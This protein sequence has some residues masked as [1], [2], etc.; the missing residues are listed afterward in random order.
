MSSD[1][2]VTHSYNALDGYAAHM[3]DA[4]AAELAS[5]PDVAMV[6]PDG[7]CQGGSTQADAPWGIS[8]ISRKDKLPKGSS[9]SS[10]D[11]I[12][13]YRP[14]CSSI[15]VYLLSTGINSRHVDFGSRARQ[16]AIFGKYHAE[17]VN[18][19]GT[20]VAGIIGGKR[21]GIAKTASIISVK[22]IG[23]NGR[24]FVS[25]MIAGVNWAVN[26]AATTHQQSILHLNFLTDT[27]NP[28][29]EQAINNA[30]SKGIHVVVPAGDANRDAKGV[31]PARMPKVITVGAVNIADDR[32][33]ESST[34][35]S[36][37]GAIVDVFAPGVAITTTWIRSATATQSITGTRAAAA[38]VTGLVAYLLAAEGPRSPADMRLRVKQL[39]INGILSNIPIGTRNSMAWN[40]GGC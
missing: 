23:D 8:R 40:G 29:L 39:A 5:S 24:G 37:F 7:E 10:L 16:G 1:L 36:N 9:A 18:G 17:D 19:N 12:F 27:P 31:S 13:D 4:R 6:V 35:G 26:H 25:N 32:W 22:V 20:F 33:L 15:N 21:F 3:T 11:Y 34:K 2:R 14:A 28:L 38:H 30:I